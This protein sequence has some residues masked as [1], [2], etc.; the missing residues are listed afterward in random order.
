MNIVNAQTKRAF[1]L[2]EL[3]VVIAVVGVLAGIAI[4]TYRQYAMRSKLGTIPAIIGEMRAQGWLYWN[5]TGR[6]P[7]AYNLGLSSTVN[8]SAVSNPA[9]ISPY[10]SSLNFGA[11]GTPQ[12]SACDGSGAVWGTFDTAALGMPS[13]FATSGSFTCYYFNRSKTMIHNCS[14]SF[15]ASGQYSTQNLIP[16]WYTCLDTACSNSLYHQQKDGYAG[17]PGFTSCNCT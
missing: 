17:N 15:N 11:Q 16:G 1:S 14:Y 6:M 8:S 2:I 13:S 4:P 10:L 5:K 7:N 9:G 12:C 3:L